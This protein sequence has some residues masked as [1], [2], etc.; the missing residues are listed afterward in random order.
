MRWLFVAAAVLAAGAA[1]AQ[2]ASPATPPAA[3]PAAPLPDMPDM[4]GMDHSKMNHSGAPPA[5]ADHDMAGM[6]MSGDMAGMDMGAMQGG[7]TGAY[8]P[9]SM[10]REASGTAWQPDASPDQGM[11]LTEGPW[12]VM[13]HGDLNAVYDSQSGPR[14][15]D[16]GFVSGMVMGMAQRP[17][18]DAGTLQL[19][20]ML[21]PEP[22]MGPAGYP[23]LLATGETANG[24]TPLVDRQHPHNFFMELSVSYAYRLDKES[25]V[26]VYAGLPGEPA[27]GPPAFMHRLSIEDS[28]EAPIS[29]HWLDST[30]ITEG[31][32]TGGVVHGDWKLEASAY[33]G[34]E[35]D[36]N[37]W[38]IEPGPL[39]STAV[40][41]SWNPTK[42]LS[43]ETSWANELSPEQLEPGVNQ[44]K[45]AAS[46]IYTVPF[47]DHGWWSS[48]AAWGRR[49]SQGVDLDAWVLESA[50]KPN[51]DWT[52]FARAEEEDNNELIPDLGDRGPVFSVGKV[53]IGA[54][55]DFAVAEHLLLGLGAL[56][57]FD[58]VPGALS[59]AYGDDPHGVM[60]FVRLKLR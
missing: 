42:M 19:R 47:G 30:H 51:A 38:A 5:L 57:A 28:P 50:V 32:V 53:S 9:Y 44:R 12:M 26:F 43:L 17:V 55:R 11:H 49:S 24:K 27:F 8:G 36:Q 37:R 56:Y 4:P 16:M 22:L 1:R 54:I 52:I 40:R 35:P 31:V 29:H 41:L 23:L 39:D 45:I 20:A 18:G 2:D 59:D 46:A 15:G 10:S 25:S 6:D 21:S 7:M 34:R 60:G 13:L 3:P 33:N 48:T 58:F 14:G